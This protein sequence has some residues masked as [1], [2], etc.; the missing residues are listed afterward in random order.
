MV[1]SEDHSCVIMISSDFIENRGGLK[2]KNVG[3]IEFFMVLYTNLIGAD[4]ILE[5]K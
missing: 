5:R 3:V 2:I 1:A 4:V